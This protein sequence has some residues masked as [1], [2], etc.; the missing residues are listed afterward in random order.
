MIY[1][2]NPSPLPSPLR[3]EGWVRGGFSGGKT[4]CNFYNC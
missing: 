1:D 3:G 4:K 2:E